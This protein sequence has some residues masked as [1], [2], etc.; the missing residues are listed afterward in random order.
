[1]GFGSSLWNNI[2][3]SA[4]NPAIFISQGSGN[5]SFLDVNVNQRRGKGALKFFLS[6]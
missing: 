1:M 6:I 3:K 4:W 5:V 2:F